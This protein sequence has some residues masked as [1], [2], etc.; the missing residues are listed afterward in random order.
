MSNERKYAA[1]G[2][3]GFERK[4][5]NRF[6]AQTAKNI[7]KKKLVEIR[8]GGARAADEL[9]DQ[10][11]KKNND[12]N[13][14]ISKKSNSMGL[15]VLMR[16]ELDRDR[17]KWRNFIIEAAMRFDADSV[18]CFGVNFVYGG[19]MTSSAGNVGWAAAVDVD[20]CQRNPSSVL[21]E[22]GSQRNITQGCGR[23]L[24]ESVS[25]G[26]ARGTMVWV[27]EGRELF[28][29]EMLK[30]YRFEPDIAFI[31]LEKRD[32][33]GVWAYNLPFDELFRLKNVL[34]VIPE[35][36]SSVI[37]EYSRR[38]MLYAVSSPEKLGR[39]GNSNHL[40]CD[41]ANGRL[42]DEVAGFIKKP[43]FPICADRIFT[44]FNTVE[45]ILS[46]GKS[47]KIPEYKI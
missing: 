13:G 2:S 7:V 14:N 30:T 33:N 46:A 42:P 40:S 45:Y 9:I 17:G 26:R 21:A 47:E 4:N 44:F 34:T 18:A 5:Y 10:L 41:I 16:S 32:K 1:S 31:L 28:S 37:S 25:R 38:G 22:K 39:A 35:N 20:E 15:E 24:S 23:A 43:S 19:L 29:P 11:L 3:N 27:V 12:D 6:V 36:E 8:R